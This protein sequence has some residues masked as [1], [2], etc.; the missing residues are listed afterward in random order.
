MIWLYE[1]LE[2]GLFLL[3]CVK[4]GLQK[5]FKCLCSSKNYLKVAFVLK[6]LPNRVISCL[7]LRK[8]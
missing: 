2:I 5:R 7:Y 1:A 4:I 8:K 3:K 6:T